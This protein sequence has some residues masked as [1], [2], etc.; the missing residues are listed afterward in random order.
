[1]TCNPNEADVKDCEVN[2][3]PNEDIVPSRA[4]SSLHEVN[5]NPNEADVKDCEANFNQ[6]EDAIK[7]QP[8][9]S[10]CGNILKTFRTFL[11]RK[12]HR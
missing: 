3:N 5:Y 4:E 6:N 10:L 2:L 11:Y 9:S 1:V 12:G 7:S 8:E